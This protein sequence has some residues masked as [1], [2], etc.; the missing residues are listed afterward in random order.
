MHKKEYMDE[1]LY[2]LIIIG[3]AAAGPAAAIYASRRHLK[4]AVVTTNIGGEVALS[5]EVENWP[6]IEHITGIELAQKFENHMKQYGPQIEMGYT[7]EKIEQ[8]GKVQV[9][10]AKNYSGEEKIYKTKTVIISTGIH[11]R[12]LNIPGETA[13]KNR[14]VTYCTVC[15][16]PLY[17]GKTTVTIGAGNAALESALMMAEIADK[18]YL[19]TK[20][21]D[22]PTNNGGFP[23]GENILIEKVKKNK[24]IEIIYTGLTKTING[25]GKVEGITY[26]DTTS[27]EEKELTVDGVMVHIGVIPNS[28]FVDCV[29]KDDIGQIQVNTRAETSCPGI[30]AAG[31]VTDNPF[32]QI[33]IAAGAGATAALAAIEYINKW[34]D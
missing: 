30:F 31:D 26:L 7:V 17:K 1:E 25:D 19:V 4:F 8:D 15:D 13:L 5:G 3:A 34:E 9:V 24:K 16:G 29:E 32:N 2:D 20:Y 27:N 10:Y 23:R 6:G 22:E 33:I 18:V 28:G 14:G 21:A 12:E 11:P